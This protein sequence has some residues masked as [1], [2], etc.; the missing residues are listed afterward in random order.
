MDFTGV[1]AKI[2]PIFII[3]PYLLKKYPFSIENLYEYV[4]PRSPELG[5][6]AFLSSKSAWKMHFSNAPC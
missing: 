3:F 4:A 1:I 2:N 6:G 5:G